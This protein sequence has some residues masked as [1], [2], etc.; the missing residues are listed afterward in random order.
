M[1]LDVS[2][3]YIFKAMTDDGLFQGSAN[4]SYKCDAK[5]NIPL[6]GENGNITVDFKQLEINP[7]PVTGSKF[8][9]RK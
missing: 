9:D 6:F 5:K 4:H 3:D 8:P 7:L 2:A 1:H